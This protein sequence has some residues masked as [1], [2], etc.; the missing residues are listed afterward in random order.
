M[1][2]NYY[3]KDVQV[4]GS[5]NPQNGVSHLVSA[6]VQGAQRGYYGGFQGANKAAILKN[7]HGRLKTLCETNFPWEH[8]KVYA[9]SLEAKGDQLTLNVDGR[10]LL[11]VRDNEYGYGMAGYA[12]YGMGRASFGDITIMEGDD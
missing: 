7:D 2:G 4:T 1:T 3:M 6:R 9:V 10:A 11:S 8:G 5:I 12:M